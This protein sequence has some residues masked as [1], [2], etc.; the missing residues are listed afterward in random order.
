M[1]NECRLTLPWPPVSTR[2]HLRMRL[3][4][5]SIWLELSR[6]GRADG[7]TRDRGQLRNN[8]AVVREVRRGVCRWPQE[9]AC[10]YRRQMAS[11]RGVP[12]D[13]RHHALSLARRRS[14][15]RGPRHV[16]AAKA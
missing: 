2:N 13:Q 16:R 9:T 7:G 3:A 4:L 6:R 1:L 5:L 15:W 14:E 11:G 10:T 8:P 12:Q